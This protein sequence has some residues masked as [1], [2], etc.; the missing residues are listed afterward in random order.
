M[1]KRP[2]AKIVGHS[3]GVD[4]KSGNR[5]KINFTIRITELYNLGFRT[6]VR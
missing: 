1:R 6:K 2:E 3:Y 4:R 5:N